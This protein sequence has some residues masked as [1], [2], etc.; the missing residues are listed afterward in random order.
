MFLVVVAVVAVTS[1]KVVVFMWCSGGAV[2]R[3]RQ[4][5]WWRL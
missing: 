4:S 3:L 5:V 2:V 1:V